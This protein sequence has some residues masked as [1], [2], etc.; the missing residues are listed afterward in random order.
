MRSILAVLIVFMHAFTC[1]NGSWKQPEGYVDIPLYK[2]LTRISFA[3]TLEAFVFLSGYIFAF[4]QITLDKTASFWNL[5]INK[6]KRLMLPSILFSAIY[7]AIFFSY[8]GFGNM[9]Y[10][11]VN[12]CGHMWFLPMLFWCFIGGWILVKVKAKDWLKIAFLI[13]LNLCAFFSLPLRISSAFTYL[14]YFYGGYVIYKN[15]DRLI[16]AITRNHI[17]WRWLIFVFLFVLLRPLRDVLTPKGNVDVVTKAV[18]LIGNHACQLL[19]ASAGLIAFW[20]TI[21]YYTQKHEL[22]TFTIKLA[23]SCFGIYL[24]QQFF[25]QLLYYKTGFPT[26]VG[27]Y[28]LPWCGFAVAIILSYFSS[29]ILLKTKVG[30]YLIG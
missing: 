17:I 27:P 7:F 9:C 12:G 11:I 2:W 5:T 10:S 28:W 18:M 24:F 26:L 8:K 19:Y 21:V 4:Q 16:P 13:A 30:K 14:V 6:L 23:S 15:K 22:K 25:L 20:A 29:D 3:F 1:Y